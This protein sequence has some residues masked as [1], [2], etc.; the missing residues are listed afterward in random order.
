MVCV[1]R[2]SLVWTTNHRSPEFSVLGHSFQLVPGVTHLEDVSLEVMLPGV[3]WVAT[4]MPAPL[5]WLAICKGCPLSSPIFSS[6]FLIQ[7]EV[8]VSFPKGFSCWWCQA[9]GS[10][11]S[12]YDSYWWRFGPSRWSSWLSFR[13]QLHTATMTWRWSWKGRSLLPRTNLWSSRYS[14]AV[15]RLHWQ[16]LPWH[17]CLYPLVGHWCWPG[18]WRPGLLP[19]DFHSVW[20]LLVDF[21]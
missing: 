8:N 9:S 20:S 6:L 11:E 21:M 1:Q 7:R 17:L 19:G 14:W 15:W 13:F 3:S 10:G 5:C 4:S 12:F 2:H 16:S 18:R